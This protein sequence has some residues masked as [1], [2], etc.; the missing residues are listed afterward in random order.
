MNN[1]FFLSS[2]SSPPLILAHS[3]KVQKDNKGEDHSE[4][5]GLSITQMN[6]IYIYTHTRTYTDIHIHLY[7]D[8]PAQGLCSSV[9]H[10]NNFHRDMY[11]IYDVATAIYLQLLDLLTEMLQKKEK[12]KH[13]MMVISTFN[14][15]SIKDEL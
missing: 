6:D 12:E 14:N 7:V 5:W 13:I 3:C 2:S 11:I 9:E 1:F 10:G 4:L 8:V 15:I